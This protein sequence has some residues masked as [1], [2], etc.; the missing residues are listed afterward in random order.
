MLPSFVISRIR[1][2]ASQTY[3]NCAITN[4]RLTRRR[5]AGQIVGH[6]KLYLPATTYWYLRYGPFL[7][8]V[9]VFED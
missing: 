5:N 9:C 8:S 3:T 4:A 6:L 7:D 1:T 2:G